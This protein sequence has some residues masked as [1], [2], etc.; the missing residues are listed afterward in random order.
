MNPM[1]Q[2]I[3][4]GFALADK[5]SLAGAV[6][7]DQGEPACGLAGERRPTSNSAS[8]R[9]EDGQPGAGT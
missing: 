3:P 7:L 5:M 1:K 8:Y 9:A 4:Q 2:K 6:S